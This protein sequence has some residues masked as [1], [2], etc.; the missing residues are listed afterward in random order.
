MLKKYYTYLPLVNSG[1]EEEW[2]QCLAQINKTRSDGNR[3]LK[4]NIFID[5]DDYQ[6]CLDFRQKVADSLKESFY[7]H[8]P[9]FNVTVHPPEEPWKI[10]VEAV[11]IPSG[12]G[13]IVTKYYNSIPYVVIE[14]NSGKEVW[15]AGLGSGLF[16]HDTRKAGSSAF[17][18][19][20]QILSNE[21]MSLGNLVRQWN[22]IGN[23]LNVKDGYQNYQVFNEVRNEYYQKYRKI[24]GYPAATGVGMKLGGVTID[25][26]AVTAGESVK[27]NAI[28]NPNQVN[29]YEYEQQVL[30][31]LAL[32]GKS[33]KNPPQFERALLLTNNQAATIY[34]SGTASIIG[35]ETIGKGNIEEQ[36]LVTIDNIK[37]LTDAERISHMINNRSVHSADFSL[38]RT[39]VKHKQDFEVVKAICRSHFPDTP[40]I[41]IQADICRDDLLTEIE[42]EF[43]IRF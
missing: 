36:T 4:L 10:A 18:Q 31:G 34:V 29:A 24:R 26:A 23:I 25:F 19:M 3:P 6:S 22:Y 7:D 9:S 2:Q 5:V 21:G 40:A 30:K 37:K 16:Q 38:V 17:D 14:T 39:Y 1:M 20:V 8:S 27:I 42:A 35:Q 12:T 11:F 43:D 13:G 28:D 41:Y 15:G 32:N 33:L